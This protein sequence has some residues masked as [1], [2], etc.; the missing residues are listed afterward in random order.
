MSPAEENALIE[1]SLIESTMQ[2]DANVRFTLGD[3]IRLAIRAAVAQERER[4]ASCADAEAS[5]EGI[6]QRIAAAIRKG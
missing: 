6:A 1:Q 2:S 3:A 4:C 5:I